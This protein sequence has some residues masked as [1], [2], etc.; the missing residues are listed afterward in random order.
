VIVEGTLDDDPATA[1][2]E[3]YEFK[4]KPG[5]P[6]RIPRQ[7]APYH[8]RLDWLMWFLALGAPAERW[9]GAL[10]EKL[11]QADPAILRLLRTDPFGGRRPTWVRAT[12]WRYRFATREERRETGMWWMR[13][14]LGDVVR[15]ARLRP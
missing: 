2:W 4:G 14:Q 15:P 5:D 13:E 3:P 8:L 10:L 11:L 6:T 1:H 7:F 12:R 9:F